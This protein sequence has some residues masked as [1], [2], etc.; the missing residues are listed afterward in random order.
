MANAN[1]TSCALLEGRRP[2]IN[3]QVAHLGPDAPAVDFC[4]RPARPPRG[5]A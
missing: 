3:V 4:V 2:T 1:L 5:R